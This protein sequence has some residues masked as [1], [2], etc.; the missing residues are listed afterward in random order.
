MHEQVERDTQKPKDEITGEVLKAVAN[1]ISSMIEFEVDVCSRHEDGKMPVLDLK[2]W[3]VRE[4]GATVIKH[5]FYKKPMA[6]RLT[7]RGHTV[8]PASQLRAMMTEEVLRRLRN[9]SP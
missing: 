4:N 9:C 6:S 2:I 8:Y 5:E 1:S 3:A 7:L